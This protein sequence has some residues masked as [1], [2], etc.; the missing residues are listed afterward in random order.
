MAALALPRPGSEYGPCPISCAHTDCAETRR[1]A[2]SDC[3]VCQM[4]I[5]YESRIYQ[6]QDGGFVHA[7]CLH[8]EQMDKRISIASPS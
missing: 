1:M 2:D 8:Q 4:P 7:S 6:E 5:G 3:R